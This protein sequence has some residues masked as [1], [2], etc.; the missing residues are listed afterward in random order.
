MKVSKYFSYGE[1]TKINPQFGINNEPTAEHL[2]SIK[3]LCE[4]VLD[5]AREFIGS[6]LGVHSVYRCP[7]YNSLIGGDPNSQHMIGQAADID[8][9]IYGHGNNKDLF[10]HILKN[11]PFDILIWEFG[12]KDRPEWIH[13][14]HRLPKYGINRRMPRRAYKDATGTHY[15]N[16]D[17]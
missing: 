13:V 1:V 12:T 2:E 11:L 15:I 6:S 4:N 17:L 8:T 9:D 14:S 7:K 5:P 10:Y 16:F 3:A